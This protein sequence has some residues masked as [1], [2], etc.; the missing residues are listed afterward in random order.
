MMWQPVYAT[1][2]F[3]CYL[4]MTQCVGGWWQQHQRLPINCRASKY[5]LLYYIS[6]LLTTQ[7]FYLV[8]FSFM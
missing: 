1:G 8:L 3:Y 2:Y 7:W 4:C 5:M 6:V